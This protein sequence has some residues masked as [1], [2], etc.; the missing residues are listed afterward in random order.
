MLL[1]VVSTILGISLATPAEIYKS[2]YASQAHSGV[3]K[4]K[5]ETIRSS[6]QFARDEPVV[7]CPAA[8]QDVTSS[9]GRGY[10][11]CQDTDFAGDATQVQD[12][13][14]SAFDCMLQCDSFAGCTRA[15]YNATRQTCYLKGTNGPWVFAG[16][17]QSIRLINETSVFTGNTKIG[18]WSP[19]VSLPVIPAG[20][21]IVPEQPK[22][23]RIMAFSSWTATEFAGPSGMTQFADYNWASG[24]VSPRNVTNTHH[25]M[26]CPGMSFLANGTMLVSG[27]SDAEAVSFYDYSTNGWTR[28]PNMSIARG[29]Q[30]SATLSDGSVFT[31]GGSWSGGTGG[32]NGVPLKNGEVYDPKA[33][34]WTIL[35]GCEVVPMLTT[36]DAEGPW[37][38][39]N[40]GWLYGWRNNSVFQAG[41]SKTMHWYGT[42]GSG[43]VQ[44]AGTRDAQ[45]DTMCGV[46]VMYDI[47][48]IFSAGGSQ[49]YTNSP[50]FKRAHLITIDQPYQPATV[51]VLPDMAFERGF[52]NVVVLPNGQVLITGGQSTSITFSD[53]Q[54]VFAPELWDPVTK[55]F[56]IM[57][58]ATIPRN[59]H[60]VS[61]LLADGRVWSAG[62]GLCSVN[63]ASCAAEDHLDGEIYAPPYLFHDDGSAAQRPRIVALE[64]DTDATG[65]RVVVGGTLSIDMDTADNHT[66][67][68]IRTGSSTHSTNTDQRRVPITATQQ[69]NIFTAQLPNDPGILIPGFWYLFAMNAAGVPCEALTVQITT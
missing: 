61:L 5:I 55:N 29:Y 54:S 69:N 9:R 40:H 14:Q 18:Q 12:F 39:D 49:S 17:M 19:A 60:S 47:G 63:M 7:S 22:S 3:T 31:I 58:P 66:F 44:E 35:P 20:A 33:N 45:D 25:D 34:T 24:A 56:T 50:A 57:A 15:S 65:W 6:P 4:Q 13:T 52:A 46:H 53:A 8:E 16:G 41:P 28:G 21:F 2:G 67:A 59:Y 26:F 42:T 30:S 32:Q 11:I 64:S 10:A 51:E 48:K 62:G 27:G 37:R 38:E 23:Y 68:L 43:S 36:Y 1:L